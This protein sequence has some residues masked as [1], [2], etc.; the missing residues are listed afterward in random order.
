MQASATPVI[1]RLGLAEALDAR[2]ANR[3][4]GNMYTPYSGWIEPPDDES[5]G[6]SI[7]RRVLDPTLR[8]LAAETPGVDL[9]TGRTV[10]GLTGRGVTLRDGERVDARL[11]V[12]ADGRGSTV[13]RLAGIRG[14]VKPHNRFFYWAYWRGVEPAGGRSRM[15]FLEPECAYTFPNEDG[16]TLI[17]VAAHR[18]R[19]PEFREDAEAAYMRRIRALPDAP[20]LDNATRESKLLGKIEMPNVMRPAARGGV[21]L[22][23]DA[24][25]ASDP[26]WGVG[27]GWAFQSAEWLVDETSEALLHGGDV[28]AAL[29]RYRRVH[30]RRL[31]PHHLQIADLAS[32]RPA[33]PLERMLYRAAARDPEVAREFATVGT[34][35]KP[36][37]TMFR[38]RT[39]AR[40]VRAAA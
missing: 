40:M 25:L 4:A 36:P 24:A 14:R 26:L 19:L 30:F 34:R 18:D 31:A 15:W 9:L 8:T 16:L 39:L 3:N 10:S 17:A 35:V 11:V 32:G 29:V 38:P 1:E 13:A 5:Y 12:G 23:G 20:R 21:A 28:D 2:G 33:K 27:C 6:Y 7:T 22:I 37:T